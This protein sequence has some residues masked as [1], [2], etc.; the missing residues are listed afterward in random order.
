VEK[1]TSPIDPDD[2][3]QLDKQMKM[4]CLFK[5]ELYSKCYIIQ[6]I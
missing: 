5:K 2:I 3:Q 6:L 1:L 4:L